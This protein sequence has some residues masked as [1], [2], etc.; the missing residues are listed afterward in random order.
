MGELGGLSPR[1]GI[2]LGIIVGL[3]STSIQSLGLTLQRKSHLIEDAKELPETRRPAYKRRKWQVGMLMFLASNIIGSTIQITTLPLPIL[4]T[5]QSAGLV[6]NT[7]FATILLK[8]PFTR[9]SLIGTLLTCAGA[10]LIATFGAIGEHAHNLEQLII[11]LKRGEF[12]AW[13]VS[14]LLVVV[15]TILLAHFL[16][17]W[18]SHQHLE[19]QLNRAHRLSFSSSGMT[20]TTPLIRRTFTQSLPQPVQAPVSRLRFIRGLAYGLISG[21]LSAHSLLMAKSAVELIVRT[22]ADRNNQFNR[23]ESWLI[24]LALLFFALSQLYYL[25]L[26]LRLCSTSVLY[27]F[28]FC[29]YNIIAILD[30]LIYFKQLSKLSPLH[31]GLVALGTLVLLAGVVCLSWRLGDVNVEEVSQAAVV[32]A[33]PLTPGMGVARTSEEQERES[34]LPSTRPRSSTSASRLSR[35]SHSPL[36]GRRSRVPTMPACIPQD[37]TRD[38]WAEL[39]DDREKGEDVL[40][41]LP[42]APSPFLNPKSFKKRRDRSVVEAV[43]SPTAI[44]TRRDST[45]PTPSRP[46]TGPSQLLANNNISPARES[47]G[48][49]ETGP[50]GNGVRFV[51][52]PDQRRAS[53]THGDTRVDTSQDPTGHDGKDRG[54]GDPG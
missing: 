30:G 39:D 33:T 4:S 28:V 11:L 38:I 25:H 3:L 41:C 36:T 7:A 31:A 54:E 29:I 8:E 40:L 51:A 35:L 12:I 16:K 13:M 42:P 10:A 6:F 47:A 44:S 49:E 32:P 53:R 20:P 15:A 26:G 46:A 37:D 23:F 48:P 2:V 45:S 18:S 52:T 5:L 17:I 14:T 27:P 22:I 34:L 21:I 1:A 24:V 9:Y 50:Q 19:R 43:S